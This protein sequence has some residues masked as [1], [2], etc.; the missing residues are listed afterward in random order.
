MPWVTFYYTVNDIA[1]DRRREGQ[2]DCFKGQ[3]TL[4]QPM[5]TDFATVKLKKSLT[6]LNSYHCANAL[7]TKFKY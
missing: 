6:T 5:G 4:V 7:K 3:D 2:M 1:R